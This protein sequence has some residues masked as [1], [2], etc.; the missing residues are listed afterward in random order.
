MFNSFSGVWNWITVRL[1][2][3]TSCSLSLLSSTIF[4]TDFLQTTALLLQVGSNTVKYTCRNVMLE[5]PHRSLSWKPWSHVRILIRDLITWNNLSLTYK[6]SLT[7]HKLVSWS[8]VAK[9]C[10][11]YQPSQ[12]RN[13]ILTF[14]K[15]LQTNFPE[16]CIQWLILINKQTRMHILQY[17]YL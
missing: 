16:K 7:Y 12:N 14:R 2:L 6:H 1:H 4:V 11:L 3:S 8:L 17:M 10:C 15:W 13:S 5:G 9:L